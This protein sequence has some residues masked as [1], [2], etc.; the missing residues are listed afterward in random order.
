[1]KEKISTDKAP[2]ATGPF[3]QAVIQ[4]GWVFTS[5]QIYLTPEGNLLEGTAEEQT[6]RVMK[7]LQAVLEA[8]GASFESV[9]KST[10]YVTDMSLYTTINEIYGGY[11]SEPFPAREVVCVKELPLGAKMEISMIA[12]V[13][14]Q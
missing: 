11:F 6:H 3:S 13:D 7:N 2:K 1:M 10:I 4:N 14:E 9:V 12:M 5:G 8:A